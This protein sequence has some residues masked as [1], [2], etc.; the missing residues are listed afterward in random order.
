MSLFV[1]FSSIYFSL[2]L[3]ENI[4]RKSHVLPITASLPTSLRFLRRTSWSFPGPYT[5]PSLHLPL[6]AHLILTSK[7]L[8][9]KSHSL[10]VVRPGFESR[11]S[12]SRSWAFSHRDT[13]F[14]F[15]PLESGLCPHHSFIHSFTYSFDNYRGSVDNVPSPHEACNSRGQEKINK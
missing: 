9:Q 14:R 10:G 7:Q 3:I 2:L 1:S 11:S 15:D 13:Y 8:S 4:K 12:G 6:F 5:Y